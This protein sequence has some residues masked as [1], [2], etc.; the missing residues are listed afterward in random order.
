MNL[1]QIRAR[2]NKRAVPWDDD[3][4]S[5]L[6]EGVASGL[7][8]SEIAVKLGRSAEATRTK[9]IAAGIHEPTARDRR[10]SPMRRYSDAFGD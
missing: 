10:Q 6:R 9:A 5:V 1:E 3:Q 7:S 4:L 2:R 8:W